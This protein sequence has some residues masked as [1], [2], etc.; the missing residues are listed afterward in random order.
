MAAA[1]RD[2]RAAARSIKALRRALIAARTK[3]VLF[4]DSAAEESRN[5]LQAMAGNPAT[6][7]QALRLAYLLGRESVL[8]VSDLELAKVLEYVD[9]TT[10]KFA[11]LKT[12]ATAL[13]RA[14]ESGRRGSE[15]MASWHRARPRTESRVQRTELGIQV[16]DEFGQVRVRMAGV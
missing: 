9:R 8:P 11:A 2:R 14:L 12:R 13:R 3:G 5:A 6:A 10:P 1:D 15:M 7:G 16:F 4:P